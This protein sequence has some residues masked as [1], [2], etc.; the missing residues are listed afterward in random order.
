[1]EAGMVI[2]RSLGLLCIVKGNIELFYLYA[3][4]MFIIFFAEFTVAIAVFVF[5]GR[6]EIGFKELLGE[7]LTV[8]GT[9]KDTT[10][11]ILA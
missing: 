5:K 10:C 1:V 9:D 2:F 4:F 3:A 6:L 7:A 8:Y 11:A